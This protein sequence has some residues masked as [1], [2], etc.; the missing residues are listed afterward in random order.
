MSD[1]SS[2]SS[3]ESL[4]LT[5]SRLHEMTREQLDAMRARVDK[6]RGYSLVVRDIDIPRYMSLA[7][8]VEWA[9]GLSTLVPAEYADTAVIDISG[10][11]YGLE[12][13]ISWRVPVQR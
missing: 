4:T 13:D 9:T 3:C 1:E 10:S 11:Q 5:L 6:R 7:D 8:A 2:S 12:A